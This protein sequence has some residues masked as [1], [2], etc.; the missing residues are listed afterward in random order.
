MMISKE[1]YASKVA[2]VTGAASGIGQ[3]TA[4]RLV[5]EGASVVGGDI[6]EGGLV[7]LAEELGERFVQQRCDVTVEA[8]VEALIATAVESFGGL[9]AAFFVAGATRVSLI[10]DMS[11]ADWDFTID[12]CLKGVFF[13][14]KHAGRQMIAQGSGGVIVNVASLNSRVPMFFNAA[15]SSA[16]AGVVMLSQSGALELGPFGIR[17]CAVSPG[18]TDTPLVGPMLAVP[19]IKAAFMERI[20]L[21]R[22][23]TPEDISSA[24]LYLAS[25][26]ASYITGVNLFVDGGWEQTTY[27]DLRPFL[28]PPQ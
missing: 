22:A 2:V 20:P 18:L 4:R 13:G 24:A 8:D 16:K 10:T 3:S 26:D 15:Y 23:A 28:A 27:P 5:A 17:V 1:R 11:E 12:L 14:V 6:D 21:Q 25:D 7:A 9:H 19:A